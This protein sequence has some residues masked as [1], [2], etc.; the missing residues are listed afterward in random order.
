MGAHRADHD[1]FV[2]ELRATPENVQPSHQGVVAAPVGAQRPDLI[3]LPDRVQIA[4]DVGA[5]ERVDGLLRV[6]DHDQRGVPVEGA[7]DDLPLDRVGVLELVDEHHPI[8]IPESLGGLG[9][10]LRVGERVAEPGEHVVI[11]E[12]PQVALPPGHLGPNRSGERDPLG[13]GRLVT[14]SVG[15]R[16]QPG[17]DRVDGILTQP[18]RFVERHRRLTGR[19]IALQVEVGGDLTGE[20]GDLVDEHR[21]RLTVAEDAEP[22]EHPQA[23]LVGGGDGGRVEPGQGAGHPGVPVLQTGA[24]DQQ[25]LERIQRPGV[26]AGDGVGHPGLQRDESLVHPRAQFVGGHPAEGDQHQLVERRASFGDVTG[27][28]CGQGVGLAGAGAG[29]QHGRAGRQLAADVELGD[30]CEP[31]EVLVVQQRLKDPPGEGA[32]PAG[33]AEGAAHFA[34]SRWFGAA[35]SRG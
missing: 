33:L 12:Q 30:S 26:A 19:R 27:G 13:G 21:L 9:A 14:G 3:R 18:D 34:R 23:E 24:V 28:Q 16:D 1:L 32:E 5:A 2:A 6:A 15:C 29:L 7:P 17:M 22:V 25:L 35:G 10:V 4:V 31:H 8:A 11:G 20:V